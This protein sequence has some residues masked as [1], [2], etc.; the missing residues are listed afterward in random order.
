MY[1]FNNTTSPNA[2]SNS[3][4]FSLV[5]ELTLICHEIDLLLGFLSQKIIY[6]IN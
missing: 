5:G 1:N 6:S 4:D 2:T 3:P